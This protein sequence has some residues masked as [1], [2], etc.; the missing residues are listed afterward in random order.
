MT[1]TEMLLSAIFQIFLFLVL[2]YG[3]IKLIIWIYAYLA[4]IKYEANL[5]LAEI[6]ARKEY[7]NKKKKEK[8][9]IKTS[10]S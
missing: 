8:R 1:Y 6:R 3:S 7:I 9:N 2:L 10:N 5:K 4:D